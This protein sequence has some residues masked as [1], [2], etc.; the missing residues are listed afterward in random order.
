MEWYG[1]VMVVL[2]N[3]FNSSIVSRVGIC[4]NDVFFIGCFF[5]Y[6]WYINKKVMRD[7][8]NK[9]DINVIAKIVKAK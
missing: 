5:L 9:H 8:K 3:T 6:F 4:L 2:S 1:M 7:V